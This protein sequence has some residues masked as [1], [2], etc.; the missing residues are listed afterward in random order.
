MHGS[1][2]EDWLL[3]DPDVE[4]ILVRIGE[5]PRARPGEKPPEQW[6]CTHCHAS[7]DGGESRCH[8]CGHD[9]EFGYR[10]GD[11]E[12]PGCGAHCFSSRSECYKCGTPRSEDAA[13]K[14]RDQ[15]Q[16]VGVFVGNLPWDINWEQLKEAF[17]EHE[18][19]HAVVKYDSEGYHRGFG[20]VQFSTLAEAQSAAAAMDGQVVESWFT[21]ERVNEAG[22]V[23]KPKKL[24]VHVD[25]KYTTEPSKIWMAPAPAKD[26]GDW[27]TADGG[28]R[29][30]GSAASAAAVDDSA[31][32]GQQDGRAGKGGR[33]WEEDWGDDGWG[34]E[35][36]GDGDWGEDFNDGD[37]WDD[38]W[39]DGGSG[40]GGGVGGGKG[41]E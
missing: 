29:V 18:P 11:W 9:K 1:V 15:T 14:V 33:E 24:E 40:G 30:V 28:D 20:I 2:V 41:S 23:V 26:E 4:P 25:K 34:D 13:I 27:A 37:E 35:D 16:D 6:T 17:A 31:E 36:W 38:G 5:D 19:L 22:F 8:V 39:G 10:P 7:V 21:D 3:E 32:D 12:C